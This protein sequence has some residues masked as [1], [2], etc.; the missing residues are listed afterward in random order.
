[1]AKIPLF[2][3]NTWYYALPSKQLKPGQILSKTLLNELIIFSRD[4]SGK[5]FAKRS[6]TKSYPIQEAQGNI[7]IYMSNDETSLI[8]EDIPRI[9][10]F[11]D[12]VYQAV[13]SI[14]LPCDVDHAVVGL[15]DPAHIA[16]VHQAWWWRS[17]ET[18][19][20]VAKTFEPSLY[21]FTMRKHPL[22]QQTFFYRLIGN[23]PQIEISFRLPGIRIEKVSTEKH[24]VCNLTA[25]TPISETE[26]EETTMF[27]TT[28]PWFPI[29]KPL[30]LWFTRSF[31]NQ[32]REILL[33]QQI[34]LKY[35]S[36]L[37]LVGDADAQA[38]W[39]YRLKAEFAKSQ[40]QGRSFVNPIKEKT[41]R[42]R[43]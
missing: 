25:I 6:E 12:Q 14:C 19:N 5:V 38:R 41:L 40:I 7:W 43:S 22:E 16:F 39:Y 24:L 35:N 31:L 29:L 17:P 27:Y 26:T 42:W 18:L 3:R 20:E 13:E 33:K 37:T 28:L 10:E 30:L 2:L 8:L 11:A 36:P 34:G 9:P 1:M 4:R 23:N 32:D 21:G 15:I